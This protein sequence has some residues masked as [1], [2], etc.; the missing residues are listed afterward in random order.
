MNKILNLRIFVP[1]GNTHSAAPFASP[2]MILTIVL[3]CLL[4][5]VS[6]VAPLLL[7]VRVKGL[8]EEKT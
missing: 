2:A 4:F 7:D 8:L 6:A 5:G 3:V 1:A